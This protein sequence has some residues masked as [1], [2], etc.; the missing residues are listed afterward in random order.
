MVELVLDHPDAPQQK[1]SSKTQEKQNP[2]QGL[3]EKA[4]AWAQKTKARVVGLVRN[5]KNVNDTL[6]SVANNTIDRLAKEPGKFVGRN[7]PVSQGIA[8]NP[9]TEIAGP[10]VVGAFEN[11][12]KEAAPLS[13]PEPASETPES[14]QTQ[15]PEANEATQQTRINIARSRLQQEGVQLTE[16][17]ERYLAN[18]AGTSDVEF[19]VTDVTASKFTEAQKAELKHMQQIEEDNPGHIDL[20]ASVY[21]NIYA[22]KVIRDRAFRNPSNQDTQQLPQADI[23]QPF[24]EPP[25]THVDATPPAIEQPSP[26]NGAEATV[27]QTPS[28]QEQFTEPPTTKVDVTP[29]DETTKFQPATEATQ[30]VTPDQAKEA[31][32]QQELIKTMIAPEGLEPGDKQARIDQINAIMKAATEKNV[33]AKDVTDIVKEVASQ[34]EAAIAAMLTSTVEELTKNAG[35]E[36]EVKSQI[37]ALQDK[38]ATEKNPITRGRMF[39]ILK[40]L[41]ILL[42]AITVSG[43][44]APVVGGIAM[45]QVKSNG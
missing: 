11:A 29:Q 1:D 9:L 35:G 6:K 5:K 42:A 31:K 18:H 15:I 10:D 33:A 7:E 27:V 28:S 2:P 34:P 4:H 30:V 26:R 41:G 44:A 37:D 19:L 43:L 38:L 25:T 45:S 17:D 20:A 12:V 23:P 40:I 13:Q 3:K 39:S 8:E 21:N 16:A 36:A 24:T 22:R 14:A 32:I